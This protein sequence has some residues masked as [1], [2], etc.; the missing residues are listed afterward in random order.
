MLG[1]WLLSGSAL[2]IV[3]LLSPLLLAKY[4]LDRL[5]YILLAVI[6]FF[7]VVTTTV[8]CLCCEIFNCTYKPDE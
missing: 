7:T 4:I 6:V 5:K 1:C 3:K 8:A 2:S